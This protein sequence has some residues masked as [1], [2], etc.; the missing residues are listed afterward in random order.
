MLFSV[1]TSLDVVP[2]VDLGETTV[3]TSSTLYY[4]ESSVFAPRIP[5]ECLV[6]LAQK[7]SFEGS[8]ECNSM[9]FPIAYST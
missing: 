4:V 1:P 7:L 2:G 9:N 5:A 8:S 6:P 3:V